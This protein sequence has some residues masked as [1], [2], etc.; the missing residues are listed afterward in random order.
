MSQNNFFRKSIIDMALIIAISLALAFIAHALRGFPPAP[1]PRTNEL[2]AAELNFPIIEAELVEQL[3]VQPDT[4][5]LDARAA[6]SYTSGHIPGALSLPVG[7]W[8]EHLPRIRHQ[9]EQA[10]F[11]IVY[12]IDLYCRDALFLAQGLADAGFSNLLIYEGGISEWRQLGYPIE[13]ER[14]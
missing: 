8:S 13:G 1:E 11:I 14:P 4:V 2:S 6:S 7:L 3:R 5:V 9:L 12:C 10:G